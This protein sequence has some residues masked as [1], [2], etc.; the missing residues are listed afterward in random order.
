MVFDLI[1]RI[2]QGS[3]EKV[4]DIRGFVTDL[5]I[6]GVGALDR[7]GTEAKRLGGKRVAIVTDKGIEK[8]G[9]LDGV[10]KVL[11]KEKLDF[12]INAELEGEPLV[13]VVNSIG[14][15]ARKGEFDLVMGVGGGTACDTSKMVSYLVTNPD[16]IVDH[17]W[18]VKTRQVTAWKQ[19]PTPLITVATTAGTGAEMSH[20][21]GAI[22]PNTEKGWAITPESPRVVIADPMMTVTC[23][24]IQTAATGIDGIGHMTQHVL[25]R[26]P[27]PLGDALAL[28]GIRIWANNLRTATYNGAD[29]RARWNLSLASMLH[30]WM[31]C[32]GAPWAGKTD[33]LSNYV[34]AKYNIPHGHL[35]AVALPPTMEFS[36]PA[37][38]DRLALIASEGYGVDIRGMSMREA[39]FKA[40]ESTAGLIKDLGLRTSL[41][42][43]N[44]PKEDIPEL[45][46]WFMASC[47]PSN[48]D[49]R[50]YTKE[51]VTGLFTRMWEGKI[52][53]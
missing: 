23:P 48:P 13:S 14:E 40:V 7:A 11:E 46:D 39:A 8:A 20:A 1:G 37:A 47:A 17:L 16:D 29:I 32:W 31:F 28:R 27:L 21:A 12:A 52:G 42:E 41:K 10:K 19:G 33:N 36:L 4:F 44:V 45:V 15:W 38:V 6:F 35:I 3:L 24:P 49:R 18:F 43:W 34:G 30:G 25:G 26:T 9:L 53:D 22:L 5:I 51:N 50:P 2:E